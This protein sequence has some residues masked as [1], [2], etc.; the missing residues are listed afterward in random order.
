MGLFSRRGDIAIATYGM[1][2]QKCEP[3]HYYHKDTKNYLL[4]IVSISRHVAHASWYVA[5]AS[6]YVALTMKQ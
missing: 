5:C 1:K 6:W 4:G 3:Q 2:H